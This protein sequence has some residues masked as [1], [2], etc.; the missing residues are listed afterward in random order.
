MSL[1]RG[2]TT[3]IQVSSL[4]KQQNDLSRCARLWNRFVKCIFHDC[5]PLINLLI[6]KGNS[7]SKNINSRL[8]KICKSLISNHQP[9]MKTDPSL[10]WSLQDFHRKLTFYGI[11]KPSRSTLHALVGG[12]SDFFYD[13]N[14]MCRVVLYLIC[15]KMSDTLDIKHCHKVVTGKILDKKMVDLVKNNFDFN[16]TA[17]NTA[18]LLTYTTHLKTELDKIDNKPTLY[19]HFKKAISYVSSLC[20]RLREHIRPKAIGKLVDTKKYL[21]FSFE[22]NNKTVALIHKQARILSKDFYY[23]PVR[24]EGNCFYLSYLSGW[25]HLIIRENLFDESIHMLLSNTTYRNNILERNIFDYTDFFVETLEKIKENPSHNGIMDILNKNNTA[26]TLSW[27]LRDFA[28]FGVRNAIEILVETG[29]YDKENDPIVQYVHQPLGYNFITNNHPWRYVWNNENLIGFYLKHENTF[30]GGILDN[31]DDLK[32][33]IL[34]T[35]GQLN[36]E[37]YCFVQGNNFVDVQRPEIAILNNHFSPITIYQ[38]MD[39]PQQDLGSREDGRLAGFGANNGIVLFRS[40][41]H[42]D[43]LIPRHSNPRNHIPDTPCILAIT[44]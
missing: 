1:P 27:Y 42:F 28:I 21:D 19:S 24:G 38:R 8:V 3:E 22:N 44:T 5:P 10:P 31:N 43:A 16:N 20:S 32:K 13:K 36:K 33:R 23:Q 18:M 15:E 25:L 2:V 12:N 29:D 41:N 30:V 35:R 11:K 26:D 7:P 34:T 14:I 40:Y 37:N 4:P 39:I 17:N 9:S 6:I